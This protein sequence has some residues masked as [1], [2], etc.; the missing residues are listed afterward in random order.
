MNQTDPATRCPTCDGPLNDAAHLGIRG[1]L[2]KGTLCGWV[3]S[4]PAT[5]IEACRQIAEA[6]S[7]WS[8]D[9]IRSVLTAVVDRLEHETV[10]PT[11]D[12]DEG[13]P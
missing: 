3:Y 12:I 6:P 1:C 2:T 11:I 13:H 5:L 10:I 4:T 9:G 8:A 7:T